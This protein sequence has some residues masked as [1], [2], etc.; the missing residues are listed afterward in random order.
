MPETFKGLSFLH[1]G[2]IFHLI[3]SLKMLD[4]IQLIVEQENME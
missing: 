2:E 1:F 4:L 3:Y